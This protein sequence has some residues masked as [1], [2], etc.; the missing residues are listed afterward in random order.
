[1]CLWNTD[2]PSGY[3]VKIWRK[4]LDLDFVQPKGLVMSV[5]CE[6]PLDEIWLLCHHPNLKY[7]D[8]YVGGIEYRW[9]Q[10]NPINRCH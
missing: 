1:M 10:D 5:K 9:S 4:I 3:K 8:L 7:Y 6:Q 2:V